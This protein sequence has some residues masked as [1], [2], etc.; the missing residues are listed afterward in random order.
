MQGKIKILV[1][2]AL[3]QRPRI[4]EICFMGL[5]RLRRHP[6]FDIQV[7]AVA[8]EPDMLP[9]CEKYNVHVVTH[10][11]LPLGRKKNFGL[12]AAKSF[13][14]D[15]LLEIGSD[16]LVLSELLDE[17][18]KAFIGTEHFFGIGDCA[19]IDSESQSCRRVGGAS[20]YGG[21]RM[22][23]RAALEK[24]NWNIWPDTQSKGLDN[25]SVF[26]LATKGGFFYQQLKPGS[27]PLVVDLKSEVN[28]WPFNHLLG[29]AYDVEK[30]LER[31]SNEEVEAI[32][33]LW[34]SYAECAP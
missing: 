30:I 13:E 14:F 8:S 19:F 25:A 31:L 17:Y 16:T 5:N 3:W 26:K 9:L 34:A 29:V 11:N 33:E 7:L 22:I 24:L 27:V 15:Y 18:K 6:E 10:D 12:Q 4:T 28:I 2:L 20:T 32:K 21:G 1:Y 23:S